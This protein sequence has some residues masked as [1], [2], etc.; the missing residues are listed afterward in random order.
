MRITNCYNLIRHRPI[1]S[2]T[3]SDGFYCTISAYCCRQTWNELVCVT[4]NWKFYFLCRIKNMFSDSFRC[5]N[6]S[7]AILCNFPTQN[8]DR[9]DD[10]NFNRANCEYFP[11]SKLKQKKERI[12]LSATMIISLNW[13]FIHMR[14]FLVR[15][16]AN[17]SFSLASQ[18]VF[19][20]F[21]IFLSFF[22]LFFFFIRSVVQIQ[23]A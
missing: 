16:C 12:T 22:F 11:R 23:I 4:L 14:I 9:N 6:R 7:N 10:D 20:L 2:Y 5:G 8:L 19:Y 15:F 17:A 21:Y 13:N 3:R 18:V 1:Q